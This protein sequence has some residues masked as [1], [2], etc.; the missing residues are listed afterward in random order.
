MSLIVR[1]DTKTTG[2]FACRP[3]GSADGRRGPARGGAVTIV[4][5]A[6]VYN[7]AIGMVIR[8]MACEDGGNKKK[9]DYKLEKKKHTMILTQTHTTV[10]NNNIR[11]GIMVRAP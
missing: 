2:N 6:I 4:V 9:Q 3:R 1:R 10:H 5:G 8:R 7:D 11:Y